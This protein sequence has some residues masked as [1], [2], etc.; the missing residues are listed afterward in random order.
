MTR[1]SYKD[2]NSFSSLYMINEVKRIAE[3]HQ[4]DFSIDEYLPI[5]MKMAV[6]ECCLCRIRR[7]N[8]PSIE[9][10]EKFCIQHDPMK[11]V[12]EKKRND[13]KQKSSNELCDM[14]KRTLI[15]LSKKKQLT[16]EIQCCFP[17]C[18]YSTKYGNTIG[19][20]Y[21][22]HLDVKNFECTFCQKGF[23]AKSTMRQHQRVH[24][25]GK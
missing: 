22:K 16:K 17:P 2:F 6:C 19:S 20:H 14:C 25:K 3:A 5:E 13:R 9:L 23:R 11:R 8:N 12:C 15:I 1:Y 4:R 7:K 18:L 10:N 21:M 24:L